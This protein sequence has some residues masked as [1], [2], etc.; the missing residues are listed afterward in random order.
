MTTSVDIRRLKLDDLPEVVRIHQCAFPNAALTQLGFKAIHRYYRWLMEGPHDADCLGAF[1]GSQLLGF[2]FGGVWRG[3]E[4]GYV[5]ANAAFLMFLILVRPWL[6]LAPQFRQ[7][8]KLGLRLL[9]L[10]RIKQVSLDP[11]PVA[12]HFGIQSIAV[13]IHYLRSGVGRLLMAE[14]EQRACFRGFTTIFLS[15]HQDNERAIHFYLSLGW[16]K[17]MNQNVWNQ[18]MLKRIG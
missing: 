17:E 12:E 13:D 4:S 9:R 5:R 10:S 15:V 18:V 7:R 14:I 3:V 2:C 11:T 1:S 16:E 8:I 6:L